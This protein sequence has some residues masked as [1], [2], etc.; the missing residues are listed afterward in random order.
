LKF[1]TINLMEIVRIMK[2][3]D[4]SEFLLQEGKKTLKIKRNTHTREVSKVIDSRIKSGSAPPKAEI[5]PPAPPTDDEAI[6]GERSD[7]YEVKTPVVG[8]FYRS[9]SPDDSPFVKVGDR[10]KGTDTIGIIEAMKSMN[11][12]K[13]DHSGI[14]K[15]IIPQ[16]GDL[17]EFNQVL[18]RI[19][20]H[21]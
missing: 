16:N 4:L 7:F 2:D 19:D 17:V 5:D 11:E 9:S 6:S 13:A 3:N 21:K 12:I 1:D 8:T 14:I 20:E 10:V 18:F 15:E